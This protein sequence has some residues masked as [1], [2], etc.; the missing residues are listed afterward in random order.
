MK[1]EMQTL[2]QFL[3]LKKEPTISSDKYS[4]FAYAY[5]YF[6]KHNIV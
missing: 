2:F 6:M 5:N 1:F 3:K 4:F